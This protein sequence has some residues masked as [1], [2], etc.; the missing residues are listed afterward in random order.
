MSEGP[1]APSSRNWEPPRLTTALVVL[2]T[3]GAVLTLARAADLLLPAAVG[4]VGAG[5]FAGALWAVG[6]DRYRVVATVVGSVL[7]V[8]VGLALAGALAATVLVQYPTVFPAATPAGIVAPTLR[9]AAT[10]ALVGCCFLAVLGAGAQGRPLE[11][12]TVHRAVAV[13]G[14]LAAVPLAAGLGGAALAVLA[15]PEVPPTFDPLT[16]VAEGFDVLSM[17]LLSPSDPAGAEGTDVLAGEFALF[18]F[19]LLVTLG[20]AAVRSVIRSLPLTEL[21]TGPDEERIRRTVARIDRVLSVVT[22]VGALAVPLLGV[23]D[24]VLSRD[25]VAEL[26]GPAATDLAYAVATSG[27]LRALAVGLVVLAVVVRVAVA[28]LRRVAQGT[29]GEAFLPLV[30]WFVGLAAVPA[31][32]AVAGPALAA[33][34]PAVAERLSGFEEVFRSLATGVVEFYGPGIVV[35][36]LVGVAFVATALV[37]AEVYLLLRTGLLASATAGSTLAG[38]G[39]VGA[40]AFGAAADLPLLLVV[41]VTGAGLAVADLGRHARSLGRE[42][43]RAGTTY[44]VE[45]VRGGTA[46]VVV[47]LAAAAALAASRVALGGVVTALPAAFPLTLTLGCA[48]TLVLLLWAR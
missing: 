32:Y 7:F 31:A 37:A 40:A 24:A 10:T 20:V 14:K 42:V 1:N 9:I 29:T 33:A 38:A 41:G 27:P 47:T 19:V 16:L 5:S 30:P 18:T 26:A 8:P 3:L 13:T 43:G 4:L 12:G 36:L 44:R 21:A 25:A 46:A 23:A 39:L 45:L 34:I 11:T 17:A 22:L 35:T 15:S 6:R 28:A 2:V 48:G